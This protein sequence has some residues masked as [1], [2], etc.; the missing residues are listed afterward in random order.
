[1]RMG[2]KTIVCALAVLCLGAF[3]AGIHVREEVEWENSWMDGTGDANLPRVLLIGDF[4][5]N[6]Y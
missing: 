2:R 3:G 6:A 5:C 4:V 1:M